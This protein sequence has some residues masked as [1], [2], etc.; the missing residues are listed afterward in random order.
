M[1][2]VSGYKT[3]DSS[4]K[5]CGFASPSE[6]GPFINFRLTYTI[7]STVTPNTTS[8]LAA[9]V[10]YKALTGF[11][12]TTVYGPWETASAG[13]HIWIDMPGFT[14]AA[15]GPAKA[16]KRLAVPVGHVIRVTYN[17]ADVLTAGW[18]GATATW[19]TVTVPSCVVA[20]EIT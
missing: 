6:F 20:E 17:D 10:A 14:G 16:V 1:A 19:T 12:S 11:E 2:T 15:L 4:W 5:S 13:V 3:V 18:G 9:K 7:G 8:E